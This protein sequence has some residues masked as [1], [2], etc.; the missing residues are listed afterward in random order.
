MRTTATNAVPIAGLAQGGPGEH[1]QNGRPWVRGQMGGRGVLQKACPPAPSTPHPGHTSP[2]LNPVLRGCLSAAI[3][4]KAGQ[5]VL[6][7]PSSGGN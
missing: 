7:Q 3:S 4:L 6:N 2:A 5:D 1:G